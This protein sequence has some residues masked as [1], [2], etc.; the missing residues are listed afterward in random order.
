MELRQLEYLVAVAEEASFTRAARRVH[1]SQSGVSAQVRQLERELGAELFDRCGRTATPTQA[2]EAALVHARAALAAA[3]AMRQAVDDV[4]GLLRGQLTIGMVTACTITGLFDA[5]DG[6]HRAHPGVALTLVED[7]S[8]ELAERARSGALDLALI[9]A[10]GALPEGLTVLPIVTERLVAAVPDSH[11]LADRARLTLAELSVFPLICM[12]R[13]TGIRAAFD[14]S[15]AA[16]GVQPAIS[17][18]ASAAA[19][20]VDLTARGLGVAILSESMATAYRDRLQAL[21]IED[22]GTPALL[23]LAWKPSPSPAVAELIRHCRR[24]FSLAGPQAPVAAPKA[25]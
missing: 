17:L 18:E 15:C 12:P 23:A 11:S 13:G 22:A 2:G 24:A 5:L 21:P 20:V 7:S 25:G 4:T 14:Q 19:A 3:A 10:A 9:G 8:A 6:F 1:I 16:C